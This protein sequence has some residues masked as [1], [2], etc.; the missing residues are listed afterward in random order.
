MHGDNRT[1]PV[2]GVV[3]IWLAEHIEP[4]RIII[5][6]FVS[7]QKKREGEKCF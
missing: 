3:M 7:E 1:K 4:R 6:W 5:I 2:T